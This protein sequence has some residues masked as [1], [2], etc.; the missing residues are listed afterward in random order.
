MS[1]QLHHSIS[2]LYNSKEEGQAV[3]T[4]LALPLLCSYF[5][6]PNEILP[7]PT[8][9]CHSILQVSSWCVI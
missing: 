5:S 9:P 3:T 2:D 6:A 8:Q 1:A 7:T 4:S